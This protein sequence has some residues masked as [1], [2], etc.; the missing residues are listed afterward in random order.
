MP[1][2]YIFTEILKHLLKKLG[3]KY[4]FNKKIKDKI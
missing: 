2:G 1:L 3:W 4:E